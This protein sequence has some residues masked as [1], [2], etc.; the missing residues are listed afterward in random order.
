MTRY[1]QSSRTDGWPGWLPGE[2]PVCAHCGRDKRESWHDVHCEQ[3]SVNNPDLRQIPW[4]QQN[5][6]G[7]TIT[8]PE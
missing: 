4:L 5:P 3:H 7:F 1:N 2:N 8:D 6:D